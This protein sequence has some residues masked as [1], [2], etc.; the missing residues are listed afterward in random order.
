MDGDCFLVTA[1]RAIDENGTE[2]DANHWWQRMYRDI[3]EQWR[4]P[5]STLGS[6]RKAFLALLWGNFT[7][8]TSNFF[9]SRTLLQRLGN[10]RPYR[11]VLDW[12]YALRVALQAPEGFRFLADQELLGYRLHG[13][14]TILSG[15]LINHVEA[16]RML[17]HYHRQAARMG[18]ALSER[19]TKRLNYL[20]RF[21][22]QEYARTVKSKQNKYWQHELDQ[23]QARFDNCRTERDNLA[24][25]CAVLAEEVAHLRKE[26]TLLQQEVRELRMSTSWR[27]TAPLRETM[28]LANKV[29]RRSVNAFSNPGPKLAE[30]PAYDRWLAEEAKCLAQAKLRTAGRIGALGWQPLVTVVMNVNHAS[31]IFLNEALESLRAQ[32]YPKW[33]LCIDHA[34]THEAIAGTVL[35]QLLGDNEDIRVLAGKG[36]TD[37]AGVAAQAAGEIICLLGQNDRLAPEALLRMVETFNADPEA[38]LAYS[39]E[40][41]I[42][43]AGRRLR[44]V[45]KPD[46]S[47][48]L[49]WSEDYVGQL[50][51]FRRAALDGISEAGKAG[52]KVE[53]VLNLASRSGALVHLA[54][55]LYHRRQIASTEPADGI[56]AGAV[57]GSQTTSRAALSNYLQERYIDHFDALE[58]SA[59]QGIL[60]PRFRL[61]KQFM[62]SLIIPTRDKAD[63]L[64]ACIDSIRDKT[65]GSDYEII[66]ID[67]GSTEPETLACFEQLRTDARIQI[68]AA[69]V[70]FNWSRLNNIGC[71]YAHGQMLVFLNNDTLIISPDWL[72]RL[73]EYA[74]LP[75][76]GVVGPLLLYPDDTIQHA[77]VVVGM[78]GWADH[79]FKGMTISNVKTPHVTPAAP[80]NVLAVTGACMAITSDKYTRL[81]GFDE[82]FEIC[83]SDVELC[84]RAHNAGLNNV[85]L[86]TA[87][88]YHLESKT[89]SPY[90]PEGDF[91]Q[92]ELKYAPYREQGD[93]YF[94][95]N[96]DIMSVQPCPGK[97]HIIV[98]GEKQ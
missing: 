32:S 42:D 10:L 59:Y 92:S 82:S 34:F 1:L 31:S 16:A 20:Q 43:S 52:G 56:Q 84:L 15:A 44:P 72:Q 47:E 62:A 5:E 33:E 38:M 11:Y 28:R 61:P 60:L 12:E 29:R 26:K 58:E 76:V 65:L 83:G 57:S 14:N 87:R 23:V 81:G 80:R 19:S 25:E 73:G 2:L 98:Q 27:I 36:D 48:I 63:L 45:F 9:L 85:Y 79:V 4:T 41:E 70:P 67:N 51:C 90:V 6:E 89:R 78:G 49:Y 21:I 93:P 91:R 39:D 13:A 30:A 97:P 94:N 64:M 8:S 66:V 50:M 54:E 74:A 18:I 35:G 7:V 17:R 37:L 86:P 3:V 88:L 77:G 55:V 40:D 69:D 24:K 96:L 46:W 22:R 68:I 71:R 95:P 53:L 75:N